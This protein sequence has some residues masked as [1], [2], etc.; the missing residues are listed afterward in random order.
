[1]GL[2]SKREKQE[3]SD[4]ATFMRRIVDLTTPHLLRPNENR[5]ENRYNRGLPVAFCP[6]VGGRPDTSVLALGFT[7]DLSDSGLSI[8]TTT[9]IKS[10]DVVYTIIVDPEITSGFWF[11]HATI[12]RRWNAFG[13]LE[14]GMRTNGYLNENY[15]AELSELIEKMSGSPSIAA[16]TV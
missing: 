6:W 10:E 1:M 4:A 15:R 16:Q 8:L 14:Y 2:F 3:M 11:F 7:K 12:V 13:F 9:E 5:N